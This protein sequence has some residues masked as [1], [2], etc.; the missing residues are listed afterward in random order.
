VGKLHELGVQMTTYARLVGVDATMA[1]FQHTSNGTVTEVEDVNTVVFSLG[2]QR[3]ATLEPGL[4]ELDIELRVIGDC[5]TPRTA[6]EA[7]FDWL[8]AGTEV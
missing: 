4:R 7:V 1:Y 8:Q 6:E 2:H 3:E 5:V